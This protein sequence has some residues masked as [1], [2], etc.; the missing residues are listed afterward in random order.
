MQVLTAVHINISVFR[1]FTTCSSV[2]GHD[3]W[4]NLPARPRVEWWENRVD[5]NTCTYLPNYM[6][7]HHN[8]PA[9]WFIEVFPVFGWTGYSIWCHVWTTDI[10]FIFSLI[11]LFPGFK[12]HAWSPVPYIR[13]GRLQPTGGPHNLLRTRLRTAHVYTYIERLRGGGINQKADIYK[14]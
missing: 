9:M 1:N 4:R 14:K 2:D 11:L 10:H 3:G 8:P 12:I 6:F 13:A 7:P 5:Q